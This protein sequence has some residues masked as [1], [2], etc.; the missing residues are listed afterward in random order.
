MK[1]GITLIAI[2][3]AMTAC[4][5]DYTCECTTTPGNSVDKYTIKSVS[6]SRAKAN[7]VSTSYE[8]NSSGTTVKVETTCTLK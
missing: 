3:A 7:C 5:K 1:K 2:L 8:D 4:K 6:K